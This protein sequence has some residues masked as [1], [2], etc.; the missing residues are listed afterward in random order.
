MAVERKDA[1]LFVE[2][3]IWFKS[4]FKA[5]FKPRLEPVAMFR[6]LITLFMIDHFLHQYG[7]VEEVF[8]S[9]IPKILKL[10]DS[11]VDQ[12]LV[13][14]ANRHSCI[15]CSANCYCLNTVFLCR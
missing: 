4:N 13:P 2:L 9:V 14:F 1:A 3:V 15:E 11:A 5:T 12:D 8:Q 7:G 6:A 10:V